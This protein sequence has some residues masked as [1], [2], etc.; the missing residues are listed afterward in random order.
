MP[1]IERAI[2]RCYEK[3]G[4]VEFAKGLREFDIELIST[5]G[6]HA[7]LRDAGKEDRIGGT[8][9]LYVVAE[10]RNFLLGQA[11]SG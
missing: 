8:G 5:E 4:L 6:T 9:S 3:D 2:L 10:A 11:T 7:A 1:K